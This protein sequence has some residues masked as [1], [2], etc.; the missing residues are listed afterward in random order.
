MNR[1]SR[2]FDAAR[3]IRL[4]LATLAA[5]AL[6]AGAWA[7]NLAIGATATAS[8]QSGGSYTPAK[9]N[10]GDV[11]TRWQASNSSSGTWLQITFS[12][13]KTV[14][15]VTLR[16]YATRITGHQLQYLN[17]ST[18]VTLAT[19]TSVG[20]AKTYSFSAVSTTAVRIYVTSA[21]S[22]PS[23]TEFEVYGSG[24][25]SSSSSS[26]TSSSTSSSSSSSSSSSVPSAC[27][28]G[29]TITGTV[30]CGGATVGTACNGQSESQ[31]PVFTLADGAAIKNVR[32]N[33]NA[34]DGIHCLGNC[35]LQNVV[36]EDV[37]EDAATMLGGAG[38][39]M[40]V[41]G[42]SAASAS[43]KVFQHNGIGS[44]IA[45]SDFQTLGTIGKLYRSCG[46][47]NGNGGPRYVTV[48]NVKIEKSGDLIGVNKNYGDKATVRNLQVKGYVAGGPKICMTFQGVTDHNG[49]STKLGEEWNTTT[50]DIS[51][52]DVTAY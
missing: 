33:A 36:W 5:A 20:A 25:S 43:D 37:C 22:Q 51:R 35:T 41:V 31:Q 2:R 45:I 17:G 29:S 14:S 15:S 9:A 13:A 21:S 3:L 52:T 47:C 4:A 23:I 50:C 39:T 19:G 28:P 27:A 30:D 42:G 10:D 24:S 32:I 12:S 44:T 48:N 16:E 18:W 6:S 8:T 26:S 7:Q 46:D 49:E 11:S 34:A 38:K 1:C 40:T